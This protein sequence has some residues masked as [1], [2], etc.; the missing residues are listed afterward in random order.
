MQK[1]IKLKKWRFDGAVCLYQTSQV[2]RTTGDLKLF[3]SGLVKLTHDEDCV[4]IIIPVSF[5]EYVDKYI[6]AF[7]SNPAFDIRNDAHIIIKSNCGNANFRI[8]KSS[9]YV[10]KSIFDYLDS[11]TIQEIK[12][13][14]MWEQKYD[15]IPYSAN[16]DNLETQE[17]SQKYFPTILTKFK[18]I[19][20]F[21][22]LYNGQEFFYYIGFTGL[23]YILIACEERLAKP[24]FKKDFMVRTARTFHD[25]NELNRY[26]LLNHNE[27]LE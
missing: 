5:N 27:Q 2:E 16:F 7:R 14:F 11:A 20:D 18:V 9:N 22:G 21:V 19:K 1:V 8:K 15:Y 13:S 6:N 25:K 17:L 10:I 12:R 23:K 24:Q 3:S 26:L 4:S